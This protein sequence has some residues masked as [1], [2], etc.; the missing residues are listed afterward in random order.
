MPRRSA[1]FALLLLIAASASL[2]AQGGA[3]A[4]VTKEMLTSPSPDDWL[5]LSRTY[6]EQRFSPLKQVNKSN[7]GQLRM[8]WTRGLPA[9]TN[10]TVP[11]VYRGVM[12]VVTPGAVV[13]ALEATTGDLIWEHRRKFAETVSRGTIESARA[14][15]L[16]IYQD[17]I[18]WT[19][20]DGYLVA[21]DAQKGTMRWETLMNAP[22][23]GAQNTSAPIVVEGK[24]IT[25]RA[26]S[27]K[28]E[29]CFIAAHDALTGKEVWKFFTAA[30]EGEPGGDTWGALPTE[31]RIASI[32]GLPGSYDPVRRTIIWATANP[33]PYPRMT[34]HGG[35]PDAIPR[36]APS[37]LYT[38]STIALD[39]DTGKL[40]WY[41]QHLPG[42]DWDSD[43][44]HERIQL[45][46]ALNP[47][48]GA[49]KWINPRIRR[50][51]QRD[52]TIT[53]GEPG[54][55]WALDR[56]TGQF[57]WAM[58]FPTDTPD[59][60]LSN[61]DVETGKTT[62]NWDKVFK[63]DG[64]LNRICFFNHKSYWPLAYHPGTNSLYVPYHDY[65][66]EMQKE[67]NA[68]GFGKRNGIIR[69]G[70]DPR[71]A[72]VLAK[73]DLS[74]GKV[75]KL[76]EGYAPG[77]GAVLATDGGLI[78]WGDMNRRFFAFDA[79][80]GKELWTGIL[81]GVIQMSTITYAVGGKQY[82]AVM[83]GDG[84]SATAGPM[85]QSKELTTPRGH[86]A[87]YVFALP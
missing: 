83:T 84:N 87:V 79:D 22:G 13:Q 3:F 12:Y 8:V 85:G 37:E 43:H 56:E 4:P 41:Y 34:R 35:N 15:S 45:R 18:Y 77:N 53:V 36:T 72:S 23:L 17:M 50:G 6:D 75:T 38:N 29:G 78:F 19:P 64:D 25:G 42:D 71:K 44:V 58:P 33:R 68:Q 63:K 80:S 16:A 24:V 55:M 54:G 66:L 51:E 5:M 52:I 2:F 28:R 7:V 48:P 27:D 30:A 9:G 47:D 82:I 73:V 32:W 60:H 11:I 74:T 76:R 10:E 31:K 1:V 14:K 46:T 86:N 70:V 67:N 61:V 26:C 40:K 21:L 49:V 81:G 39:P 20:P 69:P 65:C 62:I 59:F 57:L